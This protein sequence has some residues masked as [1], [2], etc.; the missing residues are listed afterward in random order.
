MTDAPTG[1][2]LDHDWFD[3]PL[4]AGTRLDPRSW[5]YSSY[6]FLHNISRQPV[7]LT[8]GR[9]TGV[10][11]ET[12]FDLG[13]EGRVT[14]GDFCT[15]AGPIFCTNGHVTIG[16]YVLISREVVFADTPFAVPPVPG[17]SAATVERGT[18]VG[19]D[20]WIGTRAVIVGGVSVGDGAIV[21]AGAV[22]TEDVPP[23]TIVAGTPAR[24]V[25]RAPRPVGS[26]EVSA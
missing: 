4:P 6:A 26:P 19:N 13:P 20:A 10:Y 5:V 1:V 15:I 17:G 16:N 23:Y 14:I 2:H 25:G 8:V 18:S 21:G 9:D 22:V 3:Q 12:H 7:P 24:V 11:T